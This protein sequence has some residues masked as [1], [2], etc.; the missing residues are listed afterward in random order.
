VQW[1]NDDGTAERLVGPWMIGLNI[2][3]C[4]YVGVTIPNATTPPQ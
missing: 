2:E 3:E 4:D 1:K